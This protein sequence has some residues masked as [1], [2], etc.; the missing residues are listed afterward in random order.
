M[1]YAPDGKTLWLVDGRNILHKVNADTLLEEVTLDMGADCNEMAYSQAGLVLVLN[2]AQVLWVVEPDTL[3]VIREMPFSGIRLAAGCPATPLGF[4][5]G[6]GSTGSRSATFE[7]AAVDFARGLVLQR[8]N[9]HTGIWQ[10]SGR[11]GTAGTQNMENILSMK[12]SPSGDFLYLS[13]ES[14][15]R[16]QIGDDK[17]RYVESTQ[18]LSNGHMRHLALSSDGKW[19]ATPAEA[20]SGTSYGIAVFDALYLKEQKLVLDNGPY[21][22]L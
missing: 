4:V 8:T 21:P 17:L 5:A 10:A 19:T 2:N 14:I 22:S 20:G 16:L 18:H 3:R 9:V 15:K 12:M 13:C 11:S 6:S 7:L 1:V